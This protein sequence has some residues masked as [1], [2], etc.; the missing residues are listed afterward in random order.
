MSLAFDYREMARECISEADVSTD[1]DRRKHL[2]EVAKLY[3][4]TALAMD[5]AEVAPLLAQQSYE[6]RT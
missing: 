1:P 4:Q 6:K 5:A 3:N 2:L